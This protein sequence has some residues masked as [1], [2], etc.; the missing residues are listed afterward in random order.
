MTEQCIISIEGLYEKKIHGFWL[1]NTIWF[2]HEL[3]KDYFCNEYDKTRHN[4][5]DFQTFHKSKEKVCMAKYMQMTEISVVQ[6]Q[7]LRL[8]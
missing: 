8:C 6:G 1:K 2:T 4:V 7:I 5:E 3:N